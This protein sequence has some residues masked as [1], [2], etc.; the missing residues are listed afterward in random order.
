MQV[1][2]LTGHSVA[3]NKFRKLSFVMCDQSTSIRHAPQQQHLRAFKQ[4][5]FIMLHVISIAVIIIQR[6]VLSLWNNG[7]N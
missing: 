2:E 5:V 6:H 3:E 4:C 7:T 1:K